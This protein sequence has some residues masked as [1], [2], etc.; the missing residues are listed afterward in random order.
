VV[1]LEG[2]RFITTCVRYEKALAAV[3]AAFAVGLPGNR[4]EGALEEG[5][6]D[7]VALAVFA[8]DDPVAGVGFALAGVGEDEGG[9]LALRGV[10]EKRSAGAK[11]V[12]QAISCRPC[13]ADKIYLN[14]AFIKVA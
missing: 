2:E 4:S 6:V 12:H 7:D 11:R 5:V 9:T 8:F 1:R 10:H 13:S 3:V 14:T